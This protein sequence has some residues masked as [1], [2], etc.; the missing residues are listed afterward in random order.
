[1]K[2]KYLSIALFI[3][4]TGCKDSVIPPVDNPPAISSFTAT[5]SSVDVNKP[6]L[7]SVS[8]SDKEGLDSVVIDFKDGSKKSFASAR[9]TASSDTVSHAFNNVGTYAPEATA[10]ADGKTDKKAVSI[11]VLANPPPV[12]ADSLNTIEG[13]ESGVRLSSFAYSPQGRPITLQLLNSDPSIVIT[14]TSD[15]VKV[16][17][18]TVDVNGVFSSSWKA[19]DDKG[20]V[21]TKTI[22]SKIDPRDDISG[23]VHDELEGTYISSLSPELVMQ[24]SFTGWAAMVTGTDSIK[25]SINP[26]G[27]FKF[28]KVI[29]GNHRVYRFATNGTDS[30]FVA[31]DDFTSGDRTVDAFVSTNA[32]TD[33]STSIVKPMPLHDLQ[34]LYVAVNFIDMDKT[35]ISGYTGTL[36]GID[37]SKTNTFYITG[38]DLTINGY[39]YYHLS[40]D[41]QDL[42]ASRIQQWKDL[43]PPALQ[44]KIIIY[45]AVQGEAIPQVNDPNGYP[46]PPANM[47]LWFK[48]DESAGSIKIDAN[49]QIILESAIMTYNPHVTDPNN[50]IIPQ[51]QESGSWLCGSGNPFGL[52][53]AYKTIFHEYYPS[54]S[55]MNADKKLLWLVVKHAPGTAARQYWNLP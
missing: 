31:Y 21:T 38:K 35:E 13:K 12:I 45:K 50:F 40:P 25:I 48:S 24:G 14:Q 15:S 28:P 8:S 11:S 34:D 22:V 54:K 5:P 33:N 16:K 10:Y 3:F 44:Q 47:G 30:S 36:K 19:T 49:N 9:K 53:Y 37:F 27:T 41:E 17:G 32:G 29:P 51:L 4:F 2:L 1:M 7:F 18:T 55:I 52:N 43:L 26:D 46:R 20:N 42:L 39:P 6:V 23:R